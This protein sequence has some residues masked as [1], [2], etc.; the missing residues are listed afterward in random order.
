MRPPSKAPS[1][2]TPHNPIRCTADSSA[3]SPSLCCWGRAA[4]AA[5]GTRP[6]PPTNR[7]EQ[8]DG[9][10]LGSIPAGHD[11]RI[12]PVCNSRTKQAPRLR[13]RHPLWR[14]IFKI[15]L[16]WLPSSFSLPSLLARAPGDE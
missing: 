5:P 10:T 15:C 11:G 7:Q 12:L 13:I 16:L 4:L 8:L 6:V 9:G 3:R 2:T 14:S 1:M